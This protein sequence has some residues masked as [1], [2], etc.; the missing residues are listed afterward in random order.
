MELTG[1]V[2]L[3]TGGKRIGA[4]VAAELAARGVDVALGYGRSQAEA[5]A[6]RRARERG[7][8]PRRGASGGPLEP[9]ACADAVERGGRTSAGST[10]WSTWRPSTRRRRST[11]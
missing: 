6:G 1:K 9:D 8:P 3:I 10:S 2:A 11:S 7:G 4:V 5:A